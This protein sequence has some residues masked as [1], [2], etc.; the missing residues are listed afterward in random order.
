ML[1][2]KIIKELEEI[3]ENKLNQIYEIVH[4]FRLGINAEKQTPRT[5]GLLK[6]KLGETFFDSLPEEELQLWLSASE[7]SDKKI[8][9]HS[10]EEIYNEL[11]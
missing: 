3:P 7:V 6:G 10:D 5:L 1:I 9:G 8:W 2:N 4:Y 11:L